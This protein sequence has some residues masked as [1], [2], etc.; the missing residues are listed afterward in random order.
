MKR[1][2]VTFLIAISGWFAACGT[3]T[4][5]LTLLDEAWLAFERGSY[6]SAYV[7]FSVL[8]ARNGTDAYEGLGW[9]SMRMNKDSLDA[10][11]RFFDLAVAGNTID[12]RS[13]RAFVKYHKGDFQ[14][15]VDNAE[16]ALL[17]DS[18]YIFVHD[19]TITSRYLYL[20][21]AYSYFHLND[22]ATCITKIQKIDP[23]FTASVSD[24]EIDAILL[25]KLES[26]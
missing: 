21:E 6:D 16:V 2:V 17:A 25:A 18:N 5:N 19:Q 24:P 14:A 4:S 9:T 1:L 10:A 23:D 13:G 3:D 7:E 8:I 20:Y 15:C 22:Y 11:N 12:T 26:L